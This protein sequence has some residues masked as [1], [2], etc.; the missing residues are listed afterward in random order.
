GV[1]YL[2]GNRVFRLTGQGEKWT[3]I[4][5]DLSTQDPARTTATGSGAENYGVVYTLAESPLK[6]G[7]LWAGTDDGRG[8]VT[9]DEGAHWE[10][11]TANLPAEARGLWMGRIEASPHDAN[12]AYLAV[13]THRSGKITPLAY[14]TTDLGRTWQNIAGD[15]PR[16]GPVKVVREDPKNPALLFAGTEFGLFLSLDRG[17]HWVRFC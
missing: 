13:E 4:S 11:R 2:A 1:L 7:L 10:D 9:Q 15:L 17:A 8:W 16:E 3:P 6:A 14:R 12:G 5:Q